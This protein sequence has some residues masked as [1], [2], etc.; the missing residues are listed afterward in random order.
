MKKQIGFLGGSFDPIHFGHINLAIQLKEIMQLEQVIF[1]PANISPFKTQSPPIASSEKRLEMVS[2]AISEIK[3]F[4]T[5]DYEV[6]KEGAS[7]T[8]DTIKYLYNKL[9]DEVEIRMLLTEDTLAGLEL[10]KDIEDILQIA[11]PIIG[12]RKGS[13]LGFVDNLQPKFMDVIRKNIVDTA[14][15]DISSTNIRERLKKKLYCGHLVPT[16][17]LDYIYKNE[18]YYSPNC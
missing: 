16:K 6:K 7:Y 4:V 1:C 17:V 9:G 18:L 5:L 3:S 8:I 13:P 10:W 12:T 15:L 2:L 14:K 11:P